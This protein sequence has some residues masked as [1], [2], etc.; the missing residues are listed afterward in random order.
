MI[1]RPFYRSPLSWLGLA[2][3]L[4]LVWFWPR[5]GSQAAPAGSEGAKERREPS[6]PTQSAP[7]TSAP[8][9]IPGVPSVEQRTTSAGQRERRPMTAI[10]KSLLDQARKAVET[11]AGGA[12][13]ATKE[14]LVRRTQAIEALG[15][16]GLGPAHPSSLQPLAEFSRYLDTFGTF[17]ADAFKTDMAGYFG[18][19]LKELDELPDDADLPALREKWQRELARDDLPEAILLR[20][21]DGSNSRSQMRSVLTGLAR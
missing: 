20:R 18:A 14:E 17:D 5:G 1:F 4:A 2:A 10:H 8:A 15:T 7:P 3:L 11:G 16:A 9:R 19:R 13:A 6:S 21:L 12:D